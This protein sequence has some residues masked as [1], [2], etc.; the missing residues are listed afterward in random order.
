M[1]QWLPIFFVLLTLAAVPPDICGQEAGAPG[2]RTSQIISSYDAAKNLTTVRLAPVKISDDRAHYDSV[3]YSVFYSYPGKIKRIPAKVG[4][5]L[6]TVVKRRLLKI[7]LYVVFIVDGEELFLPSSRSSRKH[8]V[9][10]KRWVGERLEFPMPYETFL[11]F[12]RAGKL[13]VSMD[14]LVFNFAEADLQ[15]L[16]DFAQAITASPSG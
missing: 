6:Q 3:S 8:P 4:L 1:I 13:A 7:D 16:R 9:A 2:P 12:T 11:M 15:Y 10:G 5:E 14:G